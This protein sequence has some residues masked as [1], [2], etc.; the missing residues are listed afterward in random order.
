MANKISAVTKDSALNFV[1]E[2]KEKYRSQRVELEDKWQQFEY[3]WRAIYDPSH[4]SYKGDSKYANPIIL[5]NI[6]AIVA[7]G[8][9]VCLFN[10]KAI[11]IEAPGEENQKAEVYKILAAKQAE[12][13]DIEGKKEM[14][15]RIMAKYGTTFVKQTWLE[16]YEEVTSRQVQQMSVLDENGDMVLDE[17]GQPLV[18]EAVVEETNKEIQY[19]GSSYELL[20]NVQDIYIDRYIEDIQDQPIVVHRMLLDWKAIDDGVK[21]G[22][23]SKEVAERIKESPYID[24]TEDQSIAEQVT[25][26]STEY[27]VINGSKKVYE[28]YEGWCTFDLY[29][30][31]EEIPTVI[32]IVNDNVLGIRE[33]PYWHKQYPF[34]VGK[35]REKEGEAYGMGAIDPVIDLWYDYNDTMNQV[36]DGRAFVLNPVVLER[37]GIKSVKGDSEIYP[38][39]KIPVKQPGDYAPFPMDLQQIGT[40]IESLRDLESR[41]NR[42]MGVTNLLNG[43]GDDSDLDETWR[44]TKTAISQSDKKFKR[45]AIRFEQKLW[46]QWLKMGLKL[47][48]QLLDTLDPYFNDLPINM[49]VDPS[50]IIGNFKFSVKGVEHFFDLQ[51]RLE[52]TI[53]FANMSTGKPWVNSQK[54]DEQIADMMGIKDIEKVIVTPPPAEKEPK[55]PANVSISLNPKDGAMI[56]TMAAQVLEQDGYELDLNQALDDAE[57]LIDRTAPT[58]LI[59]SGILPQD[60]EEDIIENAGNE[61]VDKKV[62]VVTGFKPAKGKVKVTESKTKK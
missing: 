60:I 45:I 62:E 17:A 2:S 59:S 30:N 57:I 46:Q 41:I 36:N 24:S 6:E 28:A 18:Q 39:M 52:K 58:A 38:G 1:M 33:N 55:K 51:D 26:G 23:F 14:A 42:G 37:A 49:P 5:D 12:L 9:E 25:S 43:T 10:D 7:R 47:N 8:S 34:L 13:Q 61:D 53:A 44:A 19:I 16:E 50:Q 35:Y 21:A 29:D 40:G 27:N 32:T 15:W 22:V 20:K 48:A 3:A 54:L 4:H 56:S 31:D 11:D